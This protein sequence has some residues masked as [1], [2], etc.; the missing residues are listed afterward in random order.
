MEGDVATPTGDVSHSLNVAN[1]TN[2]MAPA[3]GRRAR[4]P[5]PNKLFIIYERFTYGQIMHDP[6]DV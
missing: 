6:S 4:N 2:D 5:C 3:Q 1:A